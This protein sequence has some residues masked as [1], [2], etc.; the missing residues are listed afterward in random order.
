MTEI[1][2]LIAGQGLAGTVVAWTAL[3]R[4]QSVLLADPNPASNT[5]RAAAGLVNPILGPRLSPSWK[6]RELWAHALPFY[7][8]LE[9]D[10]SASFFHP[11]PLVRFFTDAAQREMWRKKRD[12]PEY[13]GFW[14]LCPDHSEETAF[15]CPGAAWLDL[16]TFLEASA[17]RLPVLGKRIDPATLQIRADFIQWEDIR[18]RFL[19][20]CEGHAILQ[21]PF[22]QFIPVRMAQ[23]DMI[24]LTLPNWNET[25]ILHR[26]RWV[27][28]VGDHLYRLGATYDWPGTPGGV[29]GEPAE[30]RILAALRPIL[31]PEL[32][33]PPYPIASG[34]RPMAQH[35]V[36]FLGCHPEHRRLALLNGLGAKGV[37]LTPFFAAQ[38]LDHLDSGAPLDPE[39]DARHFWKS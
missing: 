35:G 30:E 17:K 27:L 7:R 36:P 24:T 21:N 15:L 32:P 19:I 1:D 9:A 16:S 37:L 5:S 6:F 18:A 12:R 28:P 39:V 10:L 3:Q 2:Y 34:I 8:M 22:F 26:V 14:Q 33:P 29:S 25:R 38:L 11:T 23:G 13:D 20:F 4:G 31:P